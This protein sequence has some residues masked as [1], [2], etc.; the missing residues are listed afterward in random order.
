MSTV[1]R[2]GRFFI[3]VGIG[4]IAFFILSDLAQQA[5]ISVLLIGGII[6]IFGIMIIVT[7]PGPEHP[8]S[9]HFRTLRKV[10]KREEQIEGEE[11]KEEGENK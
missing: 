10:V 3:L 6:L 1:R 5:N 7:N 4:V 9:P 2:I 8:P 11:K